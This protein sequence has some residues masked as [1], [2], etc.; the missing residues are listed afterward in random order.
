VVKCTRQGDTRRPPVPA[1]GAVGAPDN[2][3]SP[4]GDPLPPPSGAV[5]APRTRVRGWVL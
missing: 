3:V 5:G 2:D 1:S 4:T